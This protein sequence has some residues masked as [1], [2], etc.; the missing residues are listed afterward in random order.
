MQI[1][2]SALESRQISSLHDAH[3]AGVHNEVRIPGA[4]LR[5]VTLLRFAFKFGFERCGINIERRHAETRAE[6]E[7]TRLWLVAQNSRD[8]CTPESP[9]LLGF[10]HGLSVTATSRAEDD[11]II[12]RCH[13]AASP[14]NGGRLALL[15]DGL[16]ILPR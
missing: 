15:G 10:K 8:P 7:N 1:N 3:E 13:G 16:L 4:Y 5:D 6:F 11:D 9:G 14:A 12:G 2:G